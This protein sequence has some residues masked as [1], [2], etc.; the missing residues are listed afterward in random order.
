MN[1]KD[2]LR[3]L[4]SSQ[5]PRGETEREEIM[6]LV[7]KKTR[8]FDRMIAA[9]NLVECLAAGLVIV[10]FVGLGLRTHD[11]L[12]KTGFLI[13][14][15][16]A[17]WIIYTLLRY[18]NTPVSAD[19]SQNLMGYT[20]ALIERYDHQI[21]LLKSVKYW[22]LLPMYVGL[23]ITS[24]ALFFEQEKPRSLG[25]QDFVM[26]AFYTAFFAAVWWLNEGYSV[27]RLRKER[28]KLLSM[29]EAADLTRG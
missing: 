25:W 15:A 13:V 28:A 29:T 24:A 7:Q 18:G 5:P 4:W 22:Y 14:A 3:E 9:R 16:G 10:L 20:R 1:G 8:R 23:L 27:G 19:P 12:M 2:E 26:P 21:R 6:A 17:A 11:A